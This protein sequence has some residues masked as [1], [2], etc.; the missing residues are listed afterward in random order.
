MVRV[1]R[2]AWLTGCQGLL[3]VA[4]LVER[5]ERDLL[6]AE[7]AYPYRL[8]SS[9]GCDRRRGCRCDCGC[10]RGYDC[11]YSCAFGIAENGTF[12]TGYFPESL[13]S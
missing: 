9:H 7:P 3:L 1:R 6:L 10:G 12:S 4:M 13:W 8:L 5:P 2:I 11:G